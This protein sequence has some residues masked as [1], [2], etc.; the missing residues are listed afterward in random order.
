MCAEWICWL[1]V[2]FVNYEFQISWGLDPA[3]VVP[4]APLQALNGGQLCFTP[5]DCPDLLF[6]PPFGTGEG[7]AAWFITGDPSSL[8][9]QVWTITPSF[10]DH[11]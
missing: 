10:C 5:E 2:A 8:S 7:G 6:D 9:A 11:R 4:A 1:P 3:E